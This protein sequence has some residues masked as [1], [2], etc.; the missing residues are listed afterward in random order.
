MWDTI[1]KHCCF[2]GRPSAQ[3]PLKHTDPCTKARPL[4][5]LS[6]YSRFPPPPPPHPPISLP[7]TLS[8]SSSSTIALPKSRHPPP[9]P[10]APISSCRS[11]PTLKF[12]KLYLLFF[13]VLGIFR[14]GRVQ[15]GFSFHSFIVLTFMIPRNTTGS[16]IP[17]TKRKATSDCGYGYEANV[18]AST[19]AQDEQTQNQTNTQ[20]KSKTTTKKN[21]AKIKGKAVRYRHHLMGRNL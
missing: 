7:P 8:L 11:F 21:T 12:V 18:V 20:N 19:W 3:T 17:L 6:F 14:K 4:P 2:V 15:V 13:L 9:P 5:D 16:G 10:R 1:D